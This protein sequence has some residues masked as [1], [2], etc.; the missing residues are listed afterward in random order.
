MIGNPGEGIR[1]ASDHGLPSY[2]SGEESWEGLN[3]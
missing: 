3:W 1:L 2:V